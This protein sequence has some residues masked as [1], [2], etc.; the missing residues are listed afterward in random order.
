MIIW[1]NY[2]SSNH[3]RKN[4]VLVLVA[5]ILTLCTIT[6]SWALQPVKPSNAGPLNS[7]RL[8][9]QE[10]Q[11]SSTHESL[12]KIKKKLSSSH[13]NV[14][15]QFKQKHGND[16]QVYL[17]PRSGAASSISGHIPLIPGSGKGNRLT[18]TE[19]ATQLGE[20]VNIVDAETVAKIGKK[21]IIDSK[22]ALNIDA[23]Q[24]G[25]VVASQVN[26]H[27]WHINAVQ[28]VN[29]I[30]A[31]DARL[32]A[33]ISHG[34]LVIIGTEKWGKI[35][36]STKPKIDESKA[37]ELGFQ[38][39]DGRRTDDRLISGPTLEIIPTAPLHLQDG[40]AY[41][42]PPGQGY[43]HKLVWTFTFKRPPATSRWEVMIDA[44]TGEILSF[45][46]LNQYLT[47][48]VTGGVYTRTSTEI[49]PTPDT[50]GTMLPDQPM[51]FADTGLEAPNDYTNSA[52]LVDYIFGTTQTTL[53]GKFLKIYDI[54]GAIS[55]SASGSI[56]LGGTNGQHDCTSSGSSPGNTAS[57]RSVYYEVSKLQEMARGYLP[58]NVWLQGRMTA[59]VNI[60]DTCNAY[61]DDSDGSVNFYQSGGGCRNTGEIASVFDHE[62]GHGL[63]YNDGNGYSNPSESYADI[64]ALYRLQSSCLGHGFFQTLNQGCG[65]TADGTG[66]NVNES[67]TGG[68]HC[69]ENCSG[70]RDA[71]WNKHTDHVP[72]TPANFVCTECFID[73]YGYNGP[74][75]REAHCESAVDRQA[76]W[77]FAARDLQT[78]PFN[79]DSNTAFLIANR[80]FYQSSGNIGDWHAC[81]CS[82]SASNGCGATNAYM[83][84]LAADDDDGDLSNGTPHMTAIYNAFNRHGIACST[85]VPVNSGCSGAPASAPVATLMS[86]SSQVELSWN[87]VPGATKYQIFRSEGDSGCDIGKALIATVTGTPS[88]TDAALAN[89]R[90]YCYTVMAVGS[91]DACFSPA[92][93]CTCA[94]PRQGPQ[95]TLQ[96]IVKDLATNNPISGATVTIAGYATATTDSSGLFQFAGIPV[97]T[98]EVQTS[99][100]GYQPH[101]PISVDISA[102]TVTPLTISLN[103]FVTTIT[104]GT[105]TDGSGHNNWPLYASITITAPGFSQSIHTDPA[106]GHYSIS[107][108]PGV[109]YTLAV[110]AMDYNSTSRTITSSATGNVENFALTVDETTCK[111]A[112]YADNYTAYLYAENFES[113]DGGYTASPASYYPTT[114]AWGIPADGPGA[115]HSGTHVWGTNLPGDYGYYED[116]YVISPPIDLSAN[117]G[118]SSYLTWWEW[119]TNQ[120]VWDNTKTD[121][122]ISNDGGATWAVAY[123]HKGAGASAW[124]QARV[125]LSPAYSVS[126]FRIRYRWQMT[127]NPGIF[128][129]DIAV[130]PATCRPVAGGRLVGN[131]YDG[132]TGA[133][134]NNALVSDGADHNA[135]SEITPTDPTLN[136]GFYSLFL[137]A[138]TPTVSA[139]KIGYNTASQAIT[140]VADTVATQ[141]FTLTPVPLVIVQGTV[142]DGGGHGWPLYAKIE[143][144]APNFT[145]TLYTDPVTGAYSV[146]LFSNTDFTFTV[147]S[148]D[149]T[150][151]VRQVTVPSTAATENFILPVAYCTALGYG[152][153][154]AGGLLYYE[155]FETGGQWVATDPIWQWIIPTFGPMA[156]HSGAHVWGPV[157][158]S[159]TSYGAGHIISPVIDLSANAG[160]SSALSWWQWY[161]VPSTLYRTDVEVSKDGGANWMKVYE[162]PANKLAETAWTRHSVQLDASYSVSTFRVRFYYWGATDQSRG[163]YVDDVAIQSQNGCPPVPG[164]LVVGNVYEAATGAAVNGTTISDGEGRTTTTV[165]TVGDPGQDDGFYVIFQP[166]GTRTLTAHY[167]TTGEAKQIQ[168]SAD[169]ASRLNFNLVRNGILQGT[170][171]N[172]ATGELLSGATV[173]ANGF[174][175]TTTDSSGHYV[176]SNLPSGTYAVTASRYGYPV[177]T[178]TGVVITSDATTTQDFSM[179]ELSQATMQ[180]TITDGSGHGWPLAAQIDITAAGYSTTAY[181]HPIT[182]QYNVTLYRDIPYT[183]R[184]SASGYNNATQNIT[185]PAGGIVNDV[186]LTVDSAPCTAPGYGVTDSSAQTFEMDN[187]G[188]TV[189][190]TTSWA[191]GVPTNGP[192]TH[193]GTRVWATNLS[194]DYADLEDGYLTSPSMDL[195]AFA[196]Q[197]AVI[198]WWQWL[199]TEAGYDF[200][201]VEISKDGGVSWL[202]IYGPVSG[203]VD[204]TWTRHAVH[205]DPTYSVS[206]FRVRFHFTSD[207]YKADAGWYIDDVSILPQ[208]SCQEQPGGLVAGTIHGADTGTALNNVLITDQAG[209]TAYS[210]ATPELPTVDDGFYS[211]FLPPGATTLTAVFPG[212]G[213]E[214][215]LSVTADQITVQD[216]N[217]SRCSYTLTPTSVIFPAA[218]GTGSLTVTTGSG[219]TWA[220]ANT[221]GWITITSGSSGMGSGSVNY[222]VSGNTGTVSRDGS[223]SIQ[224]QSFSVTQASNYGALQGFVRNSATGAPINGASVSV[225][226]TSLSTL[227]NAAG[228]Y[229]FG[230]VPIGPHDISVTATAYLPKTVNGVTVTNDIITSQDITLDESPLVTVQGTITD[231]SGH[232]WPLYAS[233]TITAAGYNQTIYTNPITGQYSTVLNKDTVY[234]FTVNSSGYSATIRNVTPPFGGSTENFALTVNLTSCSAPGY[235]GAFYAQTFESNNG[236]FVSGGT[237]S[238]WAWGIP[239][240]GPY[241]AHSGSRVW[242]T[243]LAGVYRQNEASD[244]TSPTIDLSANAGL[245]STLSWWQ[246]LSLG[247]F[248]DAIGVQVSKDGGQ[249]WVNIFSADN[250]H[251]ELTWTQHTVVLDPTFAVSN[252]KLRFS[253]YNDI[254]YTSDSV[255]LYVDDIS[256]GPA[257]CQFLSGGLVIGNVLSANT[258]AGLTGASVTDG[259]GHTTIAVATANDPAVAEGYYTLFVPA[260][261]ANLTASYPGYVN[262]GKIVTVATDTVTRQDFSLYKLGTLQGTVTDAAT[263]T[264]LSGA[265][266]TATGGYSMST[267]SSGFY[268]FTG[269]TPGSY[270]ISVIRAGYQ[271][272]TFT[273]IPVVS[274]T[275]T[276]QNL[277]LTATSPATLQGTVT[278]GSGH[279]WPLY[280]KIDITAPGYSQTIYT[281]PVTGRYSID[282]FYGTTYTVSVSAAGYGTSTRSVSLP[283]AGSTENFALTLSG[284]TAPGYTG[285]DFTETFEA[286]NGGYGI[287]GTTSWTWGIPT[288]GPGAAYSGTKVWATNL[289]GNYSS[290][291]N[292]YLTSPTIDLSNNVGNSTTLSW[293][294]WLDLQY[295]VDSSA[296]DVSKD[297]GTTWTTVYT[298]KYSVKSWNQQSVPLGPEYSVKNFRV[299]FHFVSDSS[300]EYAGWYIDDV[301][302]KSTTGC[303][304]ATGGLVIGNVFN[305]N[306]GVGFN[307]ATVTDIGGRVATTAATPLDPAVAD[308]YYTL[309][310]SSGSNSLTASAP[311]Y[312]SETKAV[313][314][315]PNTVISRDFNL[316]R[317]GTLQGTITDAATGAPLNGA[318]VTT[319]GGY[320]TT[321]NSSGFYQLN[322]MPPGTHDITVARYGYQSQ[323][324]TGITIASDG[325]V[326]RNL[327]LATTSPVTLQG[328]VTDGSGHGWP[329]Y[330][331]LDITAPGFSQ[332]IY[333]DPVTG[334]Y[335][336]DLYHG[337]TYTVAASSSG[338]NDS[339]RS[340]ILPPQG[341]SENFALTTPCTAP[342]YSGANFSIQF[343]DNNGGFVASGT[344]SWAWGIPTSGPGGAHSG[345]KLWG[346]NL[347][348]NYSN[349]EDGY[350]TSS[351]I[352]LSNNV[353]AS[354]TLSWWHW[355]QQVGGDHTSVDV[356]KDGGTSWTTVYAM[357]GWTASWLQQSITLGPE[358]S[359][360]NFRIRFHFTS[361]S[362]STYPGWY[363]DDITLK[364]ATSC[365]PASGGLVVGNIYSN[366]TGTGLNNATVTNGSGHTTTSAATPNDPALADG[367]YTLFLPTGNRTLT[368]SFT[369]YQNDAK[370]VSVGANSVTRQD[371]IVAI[372]GIL[373]GTVTNSATGTP[374]G[375]ATVTASGGYTTTTDSSGYYQFSTLPPGT[376]TISVSASGQSSQT[377]SGV[378]ISSS[379]TTTQNFTLSSC[380]YDVTPTSAILPVS[381]G[382]GT[383]QITATEGCTW[384]ATNVPTWL[385]LTPGTS[386]SGS[387]TLNFAALANASADS[388]TGTITIAG[389]AVA[390]IQAGTATPYLL[391][392][393]VTPSNTGIITG[394]GLNCPGVC[395]AFFGNGTTPTL[396]AL[397]KAGYQFS[398]WLGC[399]NPADQAC[400]MTMSTDKNLTAQFDTCGNQPAQWAGTYYPTLAE[401]YASATNGDIEAQ[402]VMFDE[403][404]LFNQDKVVTI[405][406]GYDCTYA[407]G[408][409]K[410]VVRGSLR[411]NNG[412]VK[413]GNMAILS[414]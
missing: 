335:T 21:F 104:Q 186:V 174:G 214:Q 179:T 368:A 316:I 282:M 261:T 178:A 168:I 352:D 312:L 165:P 300:Y 277:P 124:T 375:G 108:V 250:Q 156:A 270:D 101:T 407:P 145:K 72:D 348:G 4:L 332:T 202:S 127:S 264:P 86:G 239:T 328:T 47:A 74:C 192:A 304:L 386:G 330:A 132:A 102:N 353:G 177:G 153:T 93:T 103:P 226:G 364:S 280:A 402:G 389:Q 283:S 128:I 114:W 362:S 356:S 37:L 371:F 276:T 87:E 187:G 285:V 331:K 253:L 38:Y 378:V 109:Q 212:Y 377:A 136:D 125:L 340:I 400:T 233:L 28:Q 358:Y 70:V 401:A 91:P 329:L 172:S 75:G 143:I 231:G 313:T 99:A 35:K 26:D 15:G 42:G 191:W 23:T 336:V 267:N 347:A 234:T 229:G 406:G 97:G 413:I 367:F 339:T 227:T 246:W 296:V 288:S 56:N 286:G 67:Q 163:W 123:R 369:G 149:Y 392:T 96:G 60:Y 122:E 84:W 113:S 294:Q 255:G 359:V 203:T 41:I 17:D 350:L 162:L 230:T 53:T 88:Y 342:G 351:N 327:A 10:L 36:V 11:V 79:Y 5:V 394:S 221:P 137:P 324:A 204:T 9:K 222:S 49:C 302:L 27:L 155:T 51:P 55:E 59:F 13:V 20:A 180:G 319:T 40:D 216:F 183:I 395:S 218:G 120:Y 18:K 46:D 161:E 92:S 383:I 297:G 301:A 317:P 309:F 372:P 215:S 403:L 213:G 242:A 323:T 148:L 370:T 382:S 381:G 209:H 289:S 338:Y 173:T 157:Q 220:V 306:T 106:T 159:D 77:D 76:A 6:S 154:G 315:T 142:T 68:Y 69:A 144:T 210:R 262:D 130:A 33:A 265:L 252:L 412:T 275:T 232:G 194:G 45:R 380:S 410:T 164:G 318:M 349:N 50:C 184:T 405:K 105:V 414:Q 193:S 12:E 284:C 224:S 94:T 390:V 176:F 373:Q 379:T 200:A 208:S 146:A 54:C 80:I 196:G 100:Y 190:G 360:K 363:I 95:G 258:G 16:I 345:S 158:S 290:N 408:S 29:G 399:D 256:I 343:E 135:I 98:Y 90:Q 325:V 115:G 245:S 189:S 268:Q 199:R 374:I 322:A 243:N 129:D 341:L 251:N 140:V 308:G 279:G 273:G 152:D 263:G 305:T 31:R 321:T 269:V 274:D 404:L 150:T 397:A 311:G 366:N 160:Q 337:T 298:Q 257:S 117:A 197:S 354:T 361:D 307:G 238:S 62:W 376:Y 409:T 139:S 188:Y 52:G 247:N 291:E 134:I 205:L 78:A 119:L 228:Y 384:N 121:V 8:K 217:L 211:I 2:G 198:A 385:S 110:S 48:S 107:L 24:L 388:R 292:G 111:A 287:S 30:K 3:G 7:K 43:E 166:T 223:F 82:G 398:A 63:D 219:C 65:M 66:Y 295:G 365:Q 170:V 237:N 236:S 259:A 171:S 314:V 387:G 391:T 271:P 206:T 147:S 260:G 254:Y 182:G 272:Q 244:I 141:D 19:L 14:L 58:Y 334:R 138:G 167:G 310:L 1:G 73:P 185:M 225:S 249:T 71:D 175:T 85:P 34:N 39:A 133:G 57:A 32:T 396:K 293:R 241:N 116:G 151:E 64:A 248:N 131:I 333:T 195:S 126:T 346:T 25:D 89:D 61:W 240:S 357:D 235:T 320:S 44:Q 169:S 181:S 281:N 326:T 393:S 201:S 411:V 207:S 22:D 83:Q 81:S 303:Q 355:K 112:G 344:T 299:R 118:K 278:D 266:V